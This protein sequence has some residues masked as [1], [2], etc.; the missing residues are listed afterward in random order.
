MPYGKSYSGSMKSYKKSGA[1]KA[2]YKKGYG[3]AKKRGTKK[4]S[5]KN[6]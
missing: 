6:Y 5:R 1:N 3:S 2:R 4:S